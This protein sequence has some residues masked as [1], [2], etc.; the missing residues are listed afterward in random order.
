MLRD[1]TLFKCDSSSS[2]LGFCSILF[3][4]FWSKNYWIWRI[5]VG[6]LDLLVFEEAGRIW[7]AWSHKVKTN[8]MIWSKEITGYICSLTSASWVPDSELACAWC[9]RHYTRKVSNSHQTAK[10]ATA[11]QLCSLAIFLCFV[12]FCWDFA[13]ISQLLCLKLGQANDLLK[14]SS[15]SGKTL[16][17]LNL[18]VVNCFTWIFCLM[19]SLLVCL[20]IVFIFW[21]VSNYVWILMWDFLCGYTHIS[22]VK[23]E[24]FFTSLM[25]HYHGHLLTTTKFSNA[26]YLWFTG[27]KW[28]I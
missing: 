9:A 22:G 23:S 16:L 25:A 10:K 24:I 3:T 12:S 19:L 17:S 14:D 18:K 27:T 28:L 26:N 15:A 1:V 4:K 11:K 6:D 21:W 20:R 13:M 7:S 5:W 8:Q 2:M